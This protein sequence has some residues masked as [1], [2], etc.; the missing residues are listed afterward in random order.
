[1][2]YAF[3]GV[4]VETKW[5]DIPYIMRTSLPSQL[6]FD[7]TRFSLSRNVLDEISVSGCPYTEQV[8]RPLAHGWPPA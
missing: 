3:L 6:G 4:A 8:L 7:V 1:M 5:L 2:L